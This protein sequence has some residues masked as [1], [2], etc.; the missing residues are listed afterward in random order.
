[1]TEQSGRKRPRE[2]ADADT[3]AP[4]ASSDIAKPTSDDPNAAPPEEEDD[5]APLVSN[6]KMSRA[7]CK[8]HECP[9]LDS[10]S[11]QVSIGILRK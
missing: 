5:D 4:Q 6:Y 8:G 3:S 1:M 11:R 2:E 9:Y 10:I 7:V